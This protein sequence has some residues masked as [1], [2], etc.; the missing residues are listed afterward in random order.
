MDALDF[1]VKSESLFP[2][3]SKLACDVLVVPASLAPVERIFSIVGNACIGKG[4]RLI[5]N[6]LEREVLIKNNKDYLHI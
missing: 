4:N 6:N 3:L 1:W 2:I 5:G